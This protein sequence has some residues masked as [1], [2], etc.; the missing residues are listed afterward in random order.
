MAE[1]IEGQLVEA[2]TTAMAAPSD[3]ESRLAGF[4]TEAVASE[5]AP[6]GSVISAK[7]G[8]LQWQGQAVAGNKLDVIII[9]SIFE[10][11]LYE[12][13]YDPDNP[14][15]PVCF[16]FA[17]K[18]EELR[19][20]EKSEKPQHETCAGCPQNEWGT[21]ERGRGKSCKNIRR[22]AMVSAA[23]LEAAA[24]E[25]AEVAFMKLPVT[26]TKAWVNYV[27]TVATIDRRPPFGV[28]TTIGAQPD[29]KTQFKITFTKKELL[30]DP[31]ILNAVITRHE[32]Q[33]ITQV[34]PYSPNSAAPAEPKAKSKKF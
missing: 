16:A 24:V 13:T 6:T 8:V 7:A 23:P 2:Q 20:H 17:H 26:S 32:A 29:P 14:Q 3:W 18:E 1:E 9:D 4:A 11:A 31:E 33:K 10:N 28:V 5:A 30:R 22:L 12:G 34:A 25:V 19:P 27:N 15:S 21:A